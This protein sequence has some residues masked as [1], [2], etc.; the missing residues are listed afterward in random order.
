M[1]EAIIGFIGVLIGVVATLGKDFVSYWIGRRNAGRYAAV[2]IVCV[3]DQYVEKCVEVVGDDGTVEGCPAGRTVSGEEYYQPQVDSPKPPVFPNDIDWTSI[4]PDLMYQVLA[5]PNLALGTERFIMAAAEH[6]FP[7]DYAEVFQARWEGYADLG[8]EALSIVTALR[9][10]FKLP[11]PSIEI[12][13]PDWD[14]GSFFRNKKEEVL[15]MREAERAA[16][17]KMWDLMTK[18][19]AIQDQPDGS[20]V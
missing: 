7:P 8:I 14:S 11:K 10:Q 9:R 5:L 12:G 2:R 19:D 6:A 20:S 18:Q 15:R 17:A 13:N 16:N 3:L 4:N 1:S